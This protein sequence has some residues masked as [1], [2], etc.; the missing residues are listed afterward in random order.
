MTGLELSALLLVIFAAA[1]LYRSVGHGGASGYLAA[2]VL[3]GV[4]PVTMK[5]AAL[6]MNIGVAAIASWS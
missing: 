4:A 3:F 2:M 6:L 5:S 1:A